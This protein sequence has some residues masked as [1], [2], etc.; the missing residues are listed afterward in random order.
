MCKKEADEGVS[1]AY[2]VAESLAEE[3]TER[4]ATMTR[5]QIWEAADILA[6]HCVGVQ[7][8][9]DHGKTEEH[10]LADPAY[11]EPAWSEDHGDDCEDG[12]GREGSGDRTP[13]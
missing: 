3:F 5:E 4:T 13:D 9:I 10:L 6:S 12:D 1:Q 11:G 8:L 7:E 2:T